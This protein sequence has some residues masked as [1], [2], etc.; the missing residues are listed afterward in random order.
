MSD[1][2]WFINEYLVKE[3]RKFIKD[4]IPISRDKITIVYHG[5]GDGCCSAYFITKFLRK[6]GVNTPSYRW[7][8][9]ADFD[10]KCIERPLL[11]NKPYM[12]IFL[13]LPVYSR[14]DLLR[15]LR[16][17]GKVF[18]YDHHY[19]GKFGGPNL[20][21]RSKFLYINPVI[22]QDGSTPTTIFA[23]QVNGDE[24]L[25]NKEILFMGLYTESWL[26]G[27]PF[28]ED[29]DQAHK[30][31]LKEVARVV[32]SSFLIQNMNTTH[33]AL[34][35]LLGLDRPIIEM[36]DLENNKN[37]NILKNIYKLIQNEKEW[38]IYLLLQDMK[39][40]PQPKYVLRRIDSRMRLCGIIASELR[41]KYPELVVGIWQKWGSSYYCELRRGKDCP[42]NLL[43]IIDEIKREVK[44]K[45]GGGHPEAA[46]FTADQQNFT[47]AIEKMKEILKLRMKKERRETIDA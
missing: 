40:M 25:L 16:R 43:E 14:P 7:V 39:K 9:T 38:L 18:I 24:D 12:T 17:K 11:S 29:M 23:W 42:I 41:W 13:D 27:A 10:F 33:Y 47:K 2:L 31:R 21:D 35:F 20:P 26:E 34:N 32:H 46:A 22:H 8:G 45:S 19:P 15:S 5:D 4:A 30:N 3:A 6:L 1:R 36:E 28:F 44:L 37:Y